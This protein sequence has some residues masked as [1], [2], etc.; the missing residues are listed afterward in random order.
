MTEIQWKMWQFV[1]EILKCEPQSVIPYCA[2]L[3]CT[4]PAVDCVDIAVYVLYEKFDR[5]TMCDTKPTPSHSGV[6]HG[7]LVLELFVGTFCAF[8]LSTKPKR[9]LS[10]ECTF[11]TGYLKLLCWAAFIYLFFTLLIDLQHY[12]YLVI[13]FA[14]EEDSCLGRL[15]T[16]GNW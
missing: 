12:L 3:N 7:Q 13:L 10:W 2:K 11:L 1:K 14:Q 6:Y 5:F 9:V 16:V 15:N 8:F 4:H